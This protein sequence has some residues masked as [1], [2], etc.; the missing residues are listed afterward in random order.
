MKIVIK[1]LRFCWERRGTFII[2][3][4]QFFAVQVLRCVI[5]YFYCYI[6]SNVILPYFYQNNYFVYNSIIPFSRISISTEKIFWFFVILSS[7]T[8]NLFADLSWLF[9]HHFFFLFHLISLD[10][11]IVH[12]LFPSLWVDQPFT[13]LYFTYFFQIFV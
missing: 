12:I 10:T 9:L 3:Y 4:L 8:A 6:F 13:L 2:L 11:K 7:H 5:F 1:F